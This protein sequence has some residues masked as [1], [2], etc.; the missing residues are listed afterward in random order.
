[1]APVMIASV[2]LAPVMSAR[3]D[4]AE[5]DW[6]LCTDSLK[7]PTRPIVESE[8]APGNVHVAADD[9][10]LESEGI[11]TLDGNVEITRDEQQTRADHVQFNQIDD[12]ADLE[13]NIQYWDE[14]IYLEADKAHVEF[15]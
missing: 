2:S 11:S 13:G 9:A 6:P 10:D 14:A 5:S 3:A 1:M 12:T 15:N 7:I 8:L 4:E